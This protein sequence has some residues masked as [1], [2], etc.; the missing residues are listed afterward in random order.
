VQISGIRSKGFGFPGMVATAEK[1]L[2]KLSELG[3]LLTLRVAVQN[4][5]SLALMRKVAT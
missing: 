5:F 4:S 3:A 1:N 2:L